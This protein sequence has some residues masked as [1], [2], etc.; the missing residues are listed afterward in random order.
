MLSGFMIAYLIYATFKWLGY[1]LF[2][3]VWKRAARPAVFSPFKIGVIRTLLGVVLGTAYFFVVLSIAKAHGISG[4][5][6]PFIIDPRLYFL[7]LLPIRIFEWSVILKFFLNKTAVVTKSRLFV[8]TGV[9]WSFVLDLPGA[10]GL[11]A[12]VSSI[13]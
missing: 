4:G 8:S 7:G 5:R 13:C 9:I 2:L 1:T 11:I 3:F 12:F 10:L 6:N